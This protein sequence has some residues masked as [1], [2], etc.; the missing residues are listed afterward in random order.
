MTEE[1]KKWWEDNANQFQEERKIPIE[2]NYGAGGL[3]ED[4]LKLIKEIRGKKVLEIGCG[5]AQ[6]GIAFAKQGAIVTGIDIS[7]KQ[8][9]FARQLA[10]DNNVEIELYQGDIINLEK[11]NSE[12]QDIIFSSWALLYISDLQ[13]CFKEA[14]RVLKKG[15]LFVL[16]LDHPFWRTLDKKNMKLNRCYFETGI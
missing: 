9:E 8:I 10:K 7:E 6:C 11:I 13:R 14:Y 1:I 3:K 2:I 15:G 12:S 4:D 16:S 5:G